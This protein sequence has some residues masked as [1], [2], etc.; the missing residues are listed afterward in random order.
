M[1]MENYD[2]IKTKSIYRRIN[3]K[4]LGYLFVLVLILIILFVFKTNINIS[5]AITST[6]TSVLM[7]LISSVFDLIVN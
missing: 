3:K 4:M 5:V 2:L 1:T 7:I 6:L